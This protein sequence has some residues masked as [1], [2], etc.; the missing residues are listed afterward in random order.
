MVR[1]ASS[2]EA[3]GEFESPLRHCGC[4]IIGSASDCDFE[5][6]G[7]KSHQPPLS[8]KQAFVSFL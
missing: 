1:I 6:C 3:D 8:S 2:Q 5:K 7:F 4:S